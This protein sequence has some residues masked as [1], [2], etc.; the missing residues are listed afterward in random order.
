MHDL[1]TIDQVADSFQ[2]SR[3][4]VRRMIARGQLPA[5]RVGPRAIRIKAAEI[6]AALRQVP[7][8]KR[9]GQS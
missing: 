3:S 7:S 2:L 8:A 6:E 4:T 5:H 1:L 9:V